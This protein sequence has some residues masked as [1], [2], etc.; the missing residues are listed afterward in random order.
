MSSRDDIILAIDLGGTRIKAGLVS[1]DTVIE[2]RIVPTNDERG[3]TE[4]LRTLKQVG[5][6]LLGRA[7]A[8]GVALSVPAVV[9]PVRGVV[10]DVRKN[11]LGLIDF[12]L[13]DTLAEHFGLPVV[14]ENDAR[15][16]GLG[17]VRAGAARG[18]A[19]MVCLTLGTGVGCCVMIDGRIL[20]GRDGLGGILAGHLTIETY[21]P[22][23]TCGNIGCVEV[24]CRAA[25]LVD[26]VRA[27]L[28]DHPDHVLACVSPLTPEAV[29]TAASA[30][31]DLAG[32]AL[33][34]YLRHLAA[35]VTSYVHVYDPDI[36]VLGGG[37]MHADAAIVPF[38]GQ[39]VQEHSW[40]VAHHPVVVA[41]STLGD[42]A[43][44]IGAASLARGEASFS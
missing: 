23:C 42:H 14:M 24:L 28:A 4:V 36:V 2:E 38:V 37:I 43:A 10:V 19:N 7:P 32:A 26:E 12:P 16:Y 40:V 31:D 8:C 29:I 11:L 20:R 3:F 6:D 44:L 41:A 22:R 13:A 34:V 15:L 25:G 39:F 33:G 21:G 9:D 35:A 17:E 30:G 27:R 18:A 5:D 1:G